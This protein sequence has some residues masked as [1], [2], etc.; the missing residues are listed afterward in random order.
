[1]TEADEI[2][3]R[4]EVKAEV[5]C[6]IRVVSGLLIELIAKSQAKPRDL[7]AELDE[8]LVIVDA[9]LLQA[10]ESY[11]LLGGLSKEI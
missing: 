6:F 11:D 2:E 10:T 1:M 8:L 4:T 5:D 7:T 9:V 3:L